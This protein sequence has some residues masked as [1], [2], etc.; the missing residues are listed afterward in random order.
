MA[1]VTYV[2][3]GKRISITT[4]AGKRDL[5]S[6]L[7]GERRLGEKKEIQEGITQVPLK[8]LEEGLELSQ[9]AK[10]TRLNEEEIKR[11]QKL[12]QL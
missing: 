6:N 9:I 11:L 4:S 12:I 7:E 3:E 8:I 1:K 2:H 10:F 5:L